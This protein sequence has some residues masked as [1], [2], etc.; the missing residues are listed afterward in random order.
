LTLF[1]KDQII[2]ETKGN[3]FWK[4]L[5]Q[6]WYGKTLRNGK[7]I[8]GI[9]VVFVAI[10]LY[11]M[12]KISMNYNLVDNLPV[13]A[14]I[15]DDFLFFEDKFS[16]FRPVEFAI[17]VKVDSIAAD[18]Y[19]VLKEVSKIEDKL[20]ENNNFR[21]IVGITTFYKS[22]ERMNQSNRAD[23][24]IFPPDKNA[25]LRSKKLVDRMGGGDLAMMVSKDKKKTRIST[26]IADI[27]AENIKEEGELIDQWINE[28]V[29]TSLISVKRTGTG[30][31]ID[32]NAVY[33]RDNLLSGLALALILVSLL[34]ALLFRDY[35]MLFIALVP[36]FIPVLFA[37]AL[38]GFLGIDL[39][40]GVS[41]IFAIVFGI[42][43]DD[44]IHFLSKFK[45]ARDKNNTVEESIKITFEETGKAITFT[46]IILFFGF[47][48]MFFSN[49]PPSVTVG[50]LISVTLVGALICDL[51]LLPVLMRWILKD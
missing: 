6:S 45:L 4:N 15:T 9:S 33:I 35:K 32:K 28:N 5:M 51:F 16:G 36:N 29:D 37:A 27:G 48:V 13:S 46:T 24:Y 44:T 17:T 8:V 30:L 25:F 41:I 21:S 42:A 34:M 12:T 1:S 19:E 11:G 20:L 2:K 47:M 31:L 38:L 26:R 10:C 49:H 7:L 50:V 39:E 22:L 18:S 23:A 3:D 14:K 43:V 40:G